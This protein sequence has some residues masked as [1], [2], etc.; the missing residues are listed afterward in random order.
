MNI[1]LAGAE[2]Q[3][4]YDEHIMTLCHTA[5]LNDCNKIQ[6]PEK[7]SN[8]YTKVLQDSMECHSEFLQRSTRI[9]QI[10]DPKAIGI[11]IEALPYENANSQCTKVLSPL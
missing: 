1:L 11:F 2:T 3:V 7:R 9:V 4:A 10:A 8:F 5:A 6:E